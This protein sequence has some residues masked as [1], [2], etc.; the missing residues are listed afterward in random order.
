MYFIIH[1]AKKVFT[2]L[3][4]FTDCCCYTT[5][6]SEE[7]TVTLEKKVGQKKVKLIQ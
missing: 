3:Y 2:K 7:K 1:K 5:K 6:I 4:K